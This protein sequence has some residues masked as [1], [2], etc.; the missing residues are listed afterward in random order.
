[1]ADATATSPAVPEARVKPPSQLGDKI[2]ESI[3]TLAGMS[4]IVVALSMFAVLV[5]QSWPTLTHLVEFKV[6]TS[7]DWRPDNEPPIFGSLAFIYGTLASS[8]IAMLIA[9]PLGVGAAAYLAEIAPAWLRRTGSFLIELLAAVPSVVYGFW[10]MNFLRP[11]VQFVFNHMGGPNTSGAGILSAGIILA[12]MILPYITAISFDVC[13][14]VPRTQREGALALGAT[15]W[16]M[17]STAVLPYAR[18][19]IL[20]ACFLALGRALGETMA[21]TMMIGNRPEI[22]F[23][24]FAVGDSIASAIA[25][26]LNEAETPQIRSALVTLGLILL[27]ITAVLN[28]LARWL[29]LRPRKPRKRLFGRHTAVGPSVNGQPTAPARVEVHPTPQRDKFNAFMERFMTLVMASCLFVGLGPLFLILGYI[30][31]R[32]VGAIN[33]AFFTELPKMVGN[34]PGGGMANAIVGSAILV[35]LAMLFAVPI[36][37]LTAVFLSETRSRRLASAVRFVT[38]IIGGIPS[39]VIGIFAYAV[40]VLPRYGG[41]RP[42]GFSA[43]AGAFA[44]G[45]MMLPV[46]IRAAEEALRLVPKSLRQAST[47]LGAMDW[48]TA[49]RVT[50]PSALPAIITGIILAAS[51]IAGETAPLLLTAFGSEY[52]PRGLSE[53]TPFLPGYIYSYS[54]RAEPEYQRQAWAAALVLLVIVMVLNISMRY[55]SGRRV[56]AAARAE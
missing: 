5:L 39:I 27:I 21:V 16:Q 53:K 7:D 31:Y 19:G 9:V 37:V 30:T 38:D 45:I 22:N 35:G 44:L 47:A 49:L 23:S 28:M 41:D 43:W 26:R 34:Q 36:G 51:R 14:A 48:Q 15:R 3:C 18:P 11:I 2:F 50:I 13:R 1:M 20:A 55:L 8:A 6:F 52:M 32:G 40:L 46:V 10:G 33:L 29:I 24:F 12:I 25:N 54:M 42:L 4:I 56:V 17:I